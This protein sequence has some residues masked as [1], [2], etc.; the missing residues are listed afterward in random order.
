MAA[1]ALDR[2][3]LARVWE[4]LRALALAGGASGQAAAELERR[5]A[6]VEA[7]QVPSATRTAYLLPGA[8][9]DPPAVALTPSLSWPPP[10]AALAHADAAAAG[11]KGRAGALDRGAAL[12][13]LQL[14]QELAGVKWVLDDYSAD[15]EPMP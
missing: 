6:E 12:V 10:Q 8:A 2:L 7:L 13:A 14:E 15:P 11:W 1:E 3:G 4:S 9:C 5:A